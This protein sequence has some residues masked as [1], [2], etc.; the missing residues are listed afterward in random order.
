MW[1]LLYDP[2]YLA[3]IFS[4]SHLKKKPYTKRTKI[5]HATWIFF[6]PIYVD[7]DEVA[8]NL[9]VNWKWTFCTWYLTFTSVGE[10]IMNFTELHRA[11]N[12]KKLI[13][14]NKYIKYLHSF[15]IFTS[16]L[17]LVTSYLHNPIIIF[18]SIF[19]FLCLVTNYIRPWF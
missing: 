16:N 4:R 3:S 11:E 9:Y 7:H 1:H 15:I 6:H 12:T 5:E 18:I 8:T 13:I 14:N 19:K 10:A 2:L 17:L